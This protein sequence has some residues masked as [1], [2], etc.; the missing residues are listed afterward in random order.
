LGFFGFVVSAA[1][2]SEYHFFVW[3]HIHS[4]ELARANAPSAA[5]ASVFIHADYAAVTFLF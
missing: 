2:A 4:A 5:V 3:M 1:V